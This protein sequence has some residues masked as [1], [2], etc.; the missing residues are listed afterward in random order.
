MLLE[1][2]AMPLDLSTL[3]LLLLL[4]KRLGVALVQ[5]LVLVL[6]CALCYTYTS[7]WLQVFVWVVHCR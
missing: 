4:G 2:L 3:E 5:L 7:L 6:L 1:L